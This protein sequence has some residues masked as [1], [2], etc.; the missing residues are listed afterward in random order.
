MSGKRTEQ[1]QCYMDLAPL[2]LYFVVVI[3][4]QAKCH[5]LCSSE[6]VTEVKDLMSQIAKKELYDCRLY[7]PTPTDYENCS[8]SMLTCFEK[9]ATVL[10]RE[11]KELSFKLIKM[12][13][14]LA[15]Q[16]QDK[17]LTCPAC[18]VYKE[19]QANKFLDALLKTL[20]KMNANDCPFSQSRT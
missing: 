6:T 20:Q 4:R 2:F 9:E 5:A 1:H 17:R 19:E 12:L 13:N 10:I 18:E 16:L 8:R 11:S 7:T 3:M 14:Q 15:K